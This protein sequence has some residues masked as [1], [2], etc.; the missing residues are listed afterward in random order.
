M[1]ERCSF[2]TYEAVDQILGQPNLSH[3]R[4]TIIEDFEEFF[5]AA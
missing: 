4:E 2:L 1:A 3:M 5:G